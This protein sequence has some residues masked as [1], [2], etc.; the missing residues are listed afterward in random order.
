MC[1]Q[2]EMVALQALSSAY[3]VTGFIGVVAAT[4]LNLLGTFRFQPLLYQLSEY[5]KATLRIFSPSYCFTQAQLDIIMT[6]TD[7][8]E[9]AG[10]AAGTAVV[11]VDIADSAAGL[12]FVSV[13]HVWLPC[14]SKRPRCPASRLESALH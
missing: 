14:I 12:A 11:A 2:D 3:L 13:L 9:A 4:M 8:G 6:Y 1:L 10:P 5:L 7:P